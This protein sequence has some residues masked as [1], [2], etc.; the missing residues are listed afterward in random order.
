MHFQSRFIVATPAAAVAAERPDT[1]S[2][3]EVV[4]VSSR[5]VLLSWR[6]PFDGNSPVLSYIVQ[7][8]P[9]LRGSNQHHHQLQQKQNYVH[10]LHPSSSSDGLLTT[11]STGGIVASTHTGGAVVDEWQSHLTVNLTLPT[12]TS[13]STSLTTTTST[14]GM[15]NV[16]MMRS[17]GATAFDGTPRELATLA[18]FHP[19]TTYIVRMLAVNEIEH[20]SFTEPVIIK[21]REEAPAEPPAGVQV[22]AGSGIGELVVTWLAPPKDT[23]NGDLIGY[24]INCT[25]ERH[26]VN[27]IAAAN[28]TAQV[29]RTIRVDGFATTKATVARL[30][31]FRRYAISVRAVNGYDA[32][33]WSAPAFG[34]TME[35]APEAAPQN[36]SCAALSSQSIKIAWTEP[37]LQFHGGVI[38]GYKIVYRPMVQ[39]SK[40][41]RSNLNFIP[42]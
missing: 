34:T 29:R 36:V 24:T 10:R 8:R 5:S 11:D 9:L 37:G 16:P 41:N 42:A 1:P 18:G 39:E 4:E 32:G 17:A 2:H 30:R 27:Y 25:E 28:E 13:T 14:G 12:V 33:P 20:S 6:R 35:G 19:A 31:T 21:T 22:V 26:N 7:Y 23:W 38:L 3:L 15:H 40:R